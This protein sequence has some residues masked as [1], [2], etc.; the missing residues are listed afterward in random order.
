MQISRIKHYWYKYQIKW[1][2]GTISIKFYHDP[3]SINF[4]LA[5]VNA[6]YII[7]ISQSEVT[8]YTFY[9]WNNDD[10][11][12]HFLESINTQCFNFKSSN[13]RLEHI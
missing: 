10:I 5:Q 4:F 8:F 11:S 12:A 3:I 13:M 1:L 2:I 7:Q 6:W 9:W